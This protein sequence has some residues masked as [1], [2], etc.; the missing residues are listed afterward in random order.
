MDAEYLRTALG[1]KLVKCLVEV[2]ERKPADPIEYI[3]MWLHKSVALDEY[4]KKVCS[5]TLYGVRLNRLPPDRLMH[6][7]A[8]YRL[9]TVKIVRPRVR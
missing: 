6:F 5:A 8:G 7:P 3:A 9:V 2:V 4:K 1:E